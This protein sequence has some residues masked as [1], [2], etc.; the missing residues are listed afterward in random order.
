MANGDLRI[1]GYRDL[2]VIARGG[3]SAVYGAYQENFDRPVAIKVLAV[4][5]MD[6]NA[7]RRFERECAVT[8]SLSREPNI[9]TVYDSGFTAG[10]QPYIVMEYFER[11]SLAEQITQS[12]PVGLEETLRVGVK[13][14]GGLEAAHRRG[15]A[16]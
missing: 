3:F 5:G 4:D 13:L 16:S 10:G 12:G 6:A 15:C 11:G 1:D 14:A 7:R 2:H 8:G 9:V